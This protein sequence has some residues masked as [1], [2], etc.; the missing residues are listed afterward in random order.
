MEKLNDTHENQL[1]AALPA[2]SLKRLLPAL[3]SVL[4]PPAEILYNFGDD[5][6][7]LYFPGRNTVVSLLCTTD[8]RENVEVG[9]CGN[10]GA[11][12]FAAL[13]GA[14]TTAHQNLVQVPGRALRLPLAAAQDEFRRAGS[15]HDLLLRFAHSLFVQVS[16][17]ALCNRLHSDEERLARWLLLSHDRANSRQLPLPRELLAKLLG[18]SPSAASLTVSLLERAA[19]VEYN[20]TELIIPD[21][22]KLESVACS[23]YW[24]ARRE[25]AKVLEQAR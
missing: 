24:V 13:F 2:E 10:E 1:L 23:C 12:G 11:I 5:L 7:H 21:R 3:E 8:E 4:L 20:G 16:Q 19:L 25:S 22:E 17:T 6:T 15:F 18:R 14:Q 9:L